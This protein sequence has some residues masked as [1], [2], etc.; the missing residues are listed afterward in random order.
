MINSDCL[1]IQ[2]QPQMVSKI[3]SPYHDQPCYPLKVVDIKISPILEV[4]RKIVPL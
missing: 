3:I 1:E 2:I 4:Y